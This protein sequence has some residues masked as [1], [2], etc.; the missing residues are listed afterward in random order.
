MKLKWNRIL[1]VVLVLAALV[2]V[3]GCNGEKT[4]Y[5]RN[6]EDNY[7][8]SVKYD[9]NGGVFTTSTSVIVDS[10]NANNA[11]KDEN[12]MAQI[13]LITP[14]NEARGVN[15]F[16]AEKTGYFLAGWYAKCETAEDGTQTFAEP[17]DFEADRL[18]VDPKAK[19]SATEPVLT[20]YAAW[21]PLYQVEF[22]DR[23]DTSA[24][25]KVINVNPL[26]D[27][28]IAMPYWDEATGAQVLGQFPA[29][30]NKTFETAYYDAEGKKPIT[31]AVIQHP[32]TLNQENATGDSPVLKIYMDMID[33]TWFHIYNADQFISNARPSGS[34]VIHA[35]LDFTDK[36]W[37][38]SL[39]YGNFSGT[40]VGNGHTISNAV[41]EQT[42]NSKNNAGMFGSLAETAKINDLSL[43][44]V[45]FTVKA[46]TRVPGTYYGLLA[47]TVAEGA[48]L[49][50]LSIRSSQVI[51][52]E[53]AYFGT[54]DYEIGTV[55][56]M[57][58]V[59]LETAEI[60]LVDQRPAE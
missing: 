32:G 7:K 28:S 13:A 29:V 58:E 41:I 23:A 40:I 46:G 50:G 5:E 34:Y 57:G 8:I 18:T 17:W 22:Y 15:A 55:C 39:L 51:I 45:T 56:G 47:G 10:Y 38:S 1:L 24:P 6:D 52:G 48:D 53:D 37:P 59:T 16:Q 21:V 3:T 60:T 36:F 19:H 27:M 25:V 49:T 2:L 33:G 26:E 14:D 35:D 43:E 30:E 31:E 44:N 20:L 54:E 4:P 9:A 12:G 42:N 11:P